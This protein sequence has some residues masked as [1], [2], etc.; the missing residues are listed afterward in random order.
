MGYR[1]IQCVLCFPNND[2]VPMDT[3]MTTNPCEIYM[4]ANCNKALINFNYF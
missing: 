1:I 2:C 3:Y 4:F